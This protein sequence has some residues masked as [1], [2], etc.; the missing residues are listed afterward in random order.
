M[1]THISKIFNIVSI[2]I[3]NPLIQ[4]YTNILPTP[5]RL[6]Y[7]SRDLKYDF[8]LYILLRAKKKV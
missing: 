6:Y 3:V 7:W 5:I 4:K 1:M 2:H 8:P